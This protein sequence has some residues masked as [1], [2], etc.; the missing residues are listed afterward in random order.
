MSGYLANLARRGAGLAPELAPRADA[1]VPG[2]PS[3]RVELIGEREAAASPPGPLSHRPPIFQERG[4][5][6]GK[7]E[8]D[9]G[10]SLSPLPGAR[11]ARGPAPE[12]RDHPIGESHAQS[13]PAPLPPASQE[14][15]S[16]PELPA[17]PQL[18]QRITPEERPLPSAA[19][20][21]VAPAPGPEPPR[22][23]VPVPESARPAE[24]S[25]P[26]PPAPQAVPLP[27]PRTPEPALPP[28][29][30]AEPSVP[31]PTEPRI[32]VRIG[33]VEL[34]AAPPPIPP[35]PSREGRGFEDYALARSYMRRK[36]Y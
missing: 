16:P 35:P 31:E 7:E 20:V 30:R 27:S 28:R 1:S 36:W 11:R 19:P 2:F 4:D 14:K 21:P 17:A 29:L 22:V 3:E 5:A 8:Q 33:R 6:E 13:T 18:S 10:S 9:R 34:R 23:T 26:A 24:P 25:L 12:V 32:E 15:K